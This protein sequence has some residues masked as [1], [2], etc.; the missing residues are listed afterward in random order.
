MSLKSAKKKQAAAK[1]AV[2]ASTLRAM[3]SLMQSDAPVAAC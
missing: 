2:N 3:I 1:K